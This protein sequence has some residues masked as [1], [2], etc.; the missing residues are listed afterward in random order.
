MFFFQL[1]TNEI[2]IYKGCDK[3]GIEN[4]EARISRLSICYKAKI[5]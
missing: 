2:T 5:E 1:S 3:I 4:N